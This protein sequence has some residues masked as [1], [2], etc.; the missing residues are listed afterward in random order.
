MK[1]PK[2]FVLYAEQ[3]DAVSDLSMTERG[4]V[5]T[6][7]YQRIVG[8]NVVLTDETI[9]ATARMAFKFI[10]ARIESDHERYLEATKQNRE[11]QK[12]FVSKQKLTKSSQI[13]TNENNAIIRIK[14]ES[15]S[16]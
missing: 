13:L 2:G 16:E 8:E 10:V 9:S 5:L 4:Q 12:R 3:W 14:S 6:L 1:K 7:L 11:R 15:E